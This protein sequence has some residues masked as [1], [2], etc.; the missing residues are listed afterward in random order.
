MVSIIII[1]ILILISLYVYNEYTWFIKFDNFHK[2]QN[3]KF[4]KFFNIFFNTTTFDIESQNIAIKYLIDEYDETVIFTGYSFLNTSYLE[5][6]LKPT[7][8]NYTKLYEHFE[9]R[10]YN[11]T[12]LL[13]KE[14]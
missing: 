12:T 2:I 9:S 7:V 10:C 14:L 1:I 11:Q 4:C 13:A 8:S 6:I 5:Y 3:K